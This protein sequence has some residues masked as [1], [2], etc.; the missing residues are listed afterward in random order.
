MPNQSSSTGG[1]KAFLPPYM[2]LFRRLLAVLFCATFSFPWPEA[3]ADDSIA[4][5]AAG[6]ITF[7]KSDHIRMLEEFLEISTQTV[8]IRFR[9]L[10]ESDQDIHATVA[11]PLPSYDPHTAGPDDAVR[12]ARRLGETF[13]ALVNDRR[14]PTKVQRKVKCKWS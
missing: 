4:S 6:A 5:V 9:F 2:A 7:T 1:W 3:V 12:A 8:R 10:N 13:K 11:F 14:I